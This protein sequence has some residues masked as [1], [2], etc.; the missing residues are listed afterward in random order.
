MLLKSKKLLI[1]CF[2]D[3]TCTSLI[4]EWFQRCLIPLCIICACKIICFETVNALLFHNVIK[5][6]MKLIEIFLFNV[7]L[8]TWDDNFTEVTKLSEPKVTLCIIINCSLHLLRVFSRINVQ[9]KFH[10]V[11][12]PWKVC[13]TTSP[14]HLIVWQHFNYFK[15]SLKFN[16]I[17]MFQC[18]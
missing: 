2:H 4:P 16:L 7:F 9:F 12:F 5:W 13:E 10:G 11:Y 18:P 6:T 8:I 1:K 3:M 14:F 15:F 17:F